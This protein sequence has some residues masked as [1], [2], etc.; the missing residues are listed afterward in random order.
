MEITPDK[1]VAFVGSAGYHPMRAR[2]LARAMKI[3]EQNYSRFRRVLKELV[4]GGELVRVRGGRIGLPDKMSL[5][6]GKIQI[7]TKGFAFLT[8]DHESEEI[9]IRANDTKTALNGDRVV[10]RV[11][12]QR[13]GLKPEGEVVKVLE[14]AAKFVIGTYHAGKF[15]AYVEPDDPTF[16][17]DVYLLPDHGL[18]PREGQKV[19]LILQ[20]WTNQFLN[21]EGKLVEILGFPDETGVDILSVI[22]K[23]D[24]PTAFP[25]PVER[26]AQRIRADFPA[27]E[28]KGRR[29]LRRLVT[30]TIDPVDA[31]DHD[32]AVS[33]ERDAQGNYLLGVHIADVAH[34]V[35]ENSALDKEARARGTS[36][37]LVDRVLPM[38]P[39]RLSNEICSLQADQDRFTYSC[40]MKVSSQGQVL[41]Y[42]IFK[43]I[44]RSCAKLNYDQVQAYFDSGQ[45]DGIPETA[46]PK[47][48][49]M[50]KLAAIL[51]SARFKMG[52]LDFDL[53][54]PMV[55]MDENGEVVDI[56]VRPRKESH[57]LIEEFMLLANRC[58]AH[59]F[60]RLGLPTLFRVHDR[61]DAEKI[62]AFAEFAKSFGYDFKFT[63]PI[64][65]GQLAD[66]LKK[67]E[68]NPEEELLNEILLRSLKKAQYQRENIGH[69]G[70]AYEHYLHFTSPIRRYPDLVVHRLLNEIKG[71]QYPAERRQTVIPLLDRLGPHCSEREV[72]AE[73]AERETVKIK[74]A[75]YL[76]NKIG[77]VF[78][79]IISGITS[80]G[81][82][83]RLLKFSAEGMVRLSSMADDYYSV[84]LDKYVIS[85]RHNRKRYRLGDTIYVQIAAVDL[86]FYRIDLKL[87]DEQGRAEAPRSR[88]K[89]RKHGK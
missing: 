84:D 40:E 54:E 8:P 38:L 75:L 5:K 31:K 33:L 47:L 14:R 13:T 50:R 88:R 6:V 30:F 37:Y 72:I 27:A 15:F 2:E 44:I 68:G 86:V 64:K 85:G 77:D 74:Q 36:V 10:V 53:P 62:E 67:M 51:R 45:R 18:S 89:V 80:G 1:I 12:P 66:C 21:P 29:D 52:S 41:E 73:K 58:V 69:F 83:V 17:R 87:V 59:H 70:L 19:V 22:K 49:E 78:E 11:K 81:F 16:K 32:D 56:S 35:R 57:K 20:D 4:A 26:E 82:F 65:P 7:T 28:L 24:L 34:Y 43:S 3:G 55:V 71:R 76:S 23:Y 42:S 39:H 9:Y 25:V 48:T 61:P 46:A 79:G 63:D 60:I